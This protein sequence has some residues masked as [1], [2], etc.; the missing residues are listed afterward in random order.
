MADI[1]PKS[2]SLRADDTIVFFSAD[3]INFSLALEF[4]LSFIIYFLNN[5]AAAAIAAKGRTSLLNCPTG[6]VTPP[7]TAPGAPVRAPNPLPI[8]S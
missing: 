4:L 3:V 2:K 6:A 1:N 8:A 5:S 7:I